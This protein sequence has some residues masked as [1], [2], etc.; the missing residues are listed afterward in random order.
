MLCNFH[1]GDSQDRF[2]FSMDVKALYTSIP[3]EDGLTALK[4]FLD[5]RPV[6]YLETSTL[7]RLAELVLKLNTFE[8]NSEFYQQQHGVAMGTRMGTNY[9]CLFV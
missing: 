8:F 6:P 9:A 2:L 3:H 1:F 5:R 7:L 4:F